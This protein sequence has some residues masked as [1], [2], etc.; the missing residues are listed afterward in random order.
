MEQK[1]IDYSSLYIARG[2]WEVWHDKNWD[3]F[4]DK[5]IREIVRNVVKTKE[6]KNLI[7][8]GKNGTGKTMLMN[9]AFKQLF[10]DGFNVRIIDFRDLVRL[11]T[12]SFHGDDSYYELIDCDYLG[13][14]D[15]DKEFKK[16]GAGSDMIN[17]VLDYTLRYRFQRKLPTWITFNLLLSEVGTVYNQHI[18][19]LIKRS[20]QLLPFNGADYGEKL[21]KKLS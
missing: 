16:S 3:D 8:Y 17:T 1:K 21:V 9:I 11:Y 14:D 20:S 5:K 18:A 15:L 2:I 19:S 12:K 13:I 6:R 10:H 7:L 4:E